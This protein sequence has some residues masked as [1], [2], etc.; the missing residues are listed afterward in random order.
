MSVPPLAPPLVFHHD[1]R[2]V[3]QRY[4]VGFAFCGFGVFTSCRT[5]VDQI[6]YGRPLLASL[7]WLGISLLVTFISIFT[8]YQR[9]GMTIVVRDGSVRLVLRNGFILTQGN[10]SSISELK[11]SKINTGGQPGNYSIKFLDKKLIHFDRSLIGIEL[12][13][14]T[15]E[16]RTGKTF[17]R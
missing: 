3:I 7:I 5:L 11:I 17:R 9:I 6:K 13:I 12:L 1:K 2:A 15:L 16:Q 10:L 14:L 4:F 8:M